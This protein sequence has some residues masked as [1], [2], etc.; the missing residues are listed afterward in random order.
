MLTTKLSEIQLWHRNLASLIRSGL[1]LRAELGEFNGLHTV[2]GIYADGT[3]SAPLAKY[4][5]R[6]R[7]EDA[8]DIVNQ[9]VAEAPA[10]GSN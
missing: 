9:L 2:C 8:L 1:F 4:A 6:R 7:A 3:S 10:P 5:V